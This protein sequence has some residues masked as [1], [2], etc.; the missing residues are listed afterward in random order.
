MFD[1][2]PMRAL[3]L[4]SQ[5]AFKPPKIFETPSKKKLEIITVASNYHI[6]VNCNAEFPE[7]KI[8]MFGS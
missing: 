7:K 8:K 6:E 1:L 2:H 3:F 5:K 4:M